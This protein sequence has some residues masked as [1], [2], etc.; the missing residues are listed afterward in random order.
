M[1]KTKFET[2]LKAFFPDIWEFYMLTKHDK[3]VK[4]V[5]D[6]ISLFRKLDKCGKINISYTNGKINWIEVTEKHYD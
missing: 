5:L 2:D 4:K 1:K 6:T 3:K